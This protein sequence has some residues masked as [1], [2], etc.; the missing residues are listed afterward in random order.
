MAT[1]PTTDSIRT[2]KTV[3][4][5]YLERYAGHGSYGLVYKVRLESRPDSVPLALKI[6]MAPN[7][8]RLVREGELLSRV[9]HSSIPGLVDRG[10]WHSVEGLAYPYVVMQWIEGQPMY[11]WARM[12]GASSRQVLRVL[13]QVAGALEAV[14]AVGALHRD[15]KGDNILV[16]P[17]G[18]A[19][20]TDFGS[21]TWAE[22]SPLTETLMP[23]GTRGYRGPEALRFQ[24]SHSGQV[25]A[26]YVART[27]DDLY[28]LGVSGY[29]VVTGEHPP[30][31]TEQEARNSPYQAP[32]S[33]RRP[34]QA[35]NARVVPELASLIER[36]LSAEPEAR[37]SAREVA[38]AAKIATQQAG[39]EAD[40]PLA[41]APKEPPAAKV[42]A[43]PVPVRA[44]PHPRETVT[45][46]KLGLLAMVPLMFGGMAWYS[47]S[48]LRA[49]TSQSA[50]V[51]DL[52]E[53][54][55]RLREISVGDASVPASVGREDLETGPSS[56]SKEIPAEPLPGQRRK[57]CR[58]REVEIHGGCW[59]KFA[60]LIPPCGN[61]WYEWQG[62][63]YE[64][65]YMQ[66]RPPTSD[67]N[68][69]Q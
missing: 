17:V 20:L 23:P 10:V 28:A 44:E 2:G 69:Q 24:R 62:S 53:K 27:F 40:V 22:A 6:A 32:L 3:G 30:P 11:R 55:E 48:G 57:P 5:W 51:D 67:K 38:G 52:E 37:G 60:D 56:L 14:H 43:A 31:G 15:V 68:K 13:E 33:A 45:L 36:M 29:R 7:D 26:R 58:P 34:P 59:A 16:E 61:D 19:F 41:E 54:A 63:C 35:L 1:E 18:R 8:Q 9:H 42:V 21:G 50:Q 47:H 4:R 39:P 49:P 25:H 65:I 66:G 64:V 12:H 46:W